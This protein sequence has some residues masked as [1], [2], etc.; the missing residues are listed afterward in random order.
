MSGSLSVL[1]AG[2]P[3]LVA[4]GLLAARRVAWAAPAALVTA[5]V[6]I[7]LRFPTPLADLVDVLAGGL[8][9]LVEVAGLLGAGLVLARVLDAVGAQAA[10][11][12]HLT[13]SGVTPT[14]TVLLVVL[15]LTPF[16]EAVTGF[17]VGAVIAV[18]VLLGLGLPRLRAAAV[19][20]LGLNLVPWGGMAVGTLV[21][22]DLGA[23]PV[24][25]LG[26][27]SVPWNVPVSLAAAVVAVALLRRG[28]PRGR[29]WLEVLGT[30]A[31]QHGL[32]LA[33]VLTVGTV[34]AAAVSS[35]VLLALLVLR[36]RLLDGVTGTPPRA[37]RPALV[38]GAVLL[39]GLV[40]SRAL[41]GRL[42]A[43]DA[44]PGP[45]ALVLSSPVPWM[46]AAAAISWWGGRRVRD[47]GNPPD[48]RVVLRTAGRLWAPV[49]A[50]TLGFLVLGLLMS[51]TGM[52]ATL[53]EAATRHLGVGYLLVGPLLS[54]LGGYLTGSNA[55]SASMFAPSAAGAA[56]GLGVP[57]EQV[58][59]TQGVTASALAAASPARVALVVAAVGEPEAAGRV[60]RLVLAGAGTASLG[61]ALAAL[62]LG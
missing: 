55:G 27:V 33:A 14:R 22:A 59:A 52:S 6:L 60:T 50:T 9:T 20:L 11:A 40:A 48:G 24:D 32:L 44:D 45:L 1:A 29:D 49:A 57:A 23:V 47:P 31:L 2:L 5:A 25:R 21:A 16:T 37:L 53:A 38:A 43:P 62:A 42:G 46:L 19:A 28:V 36:G 34:P 10:M 7:P 13:R 35:T 58:L 39:L 8:P 30:V 12:E 18:P 51:G 17:G 56:P 54:A 26:L 15:A 41:T 61:V 3:V 4:L